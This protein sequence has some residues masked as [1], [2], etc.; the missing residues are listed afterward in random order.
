LAL[1]L[2]LRGAKHHADQ[3]TCARQ[4]LGEVELR[5][6]G[7]PDDR[8]KSFQL[9]CK[10]FDGVAN[11]GCDRKSGKGR[12]G[13]YSQVLEVEW[14]HFL[15]RIRPHLGIASVWSGNGL[16]I[17]TP[18]AEVALIDQMA[19]Q[20][21]IASPEISSGLPSPPNTDALTAPAER[22]RLNTSGPA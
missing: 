19:K 13:D 11:I 9:S 15:G 10:V 2:R 6:D 7:F 5:Q 16:K 14:S 18:E 3:F 1:S 8:T 12:R 17:L 22:R 20:S 21:V 4:F